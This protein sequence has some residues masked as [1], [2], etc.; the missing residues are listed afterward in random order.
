MKKALIWIMLFFYL[1]L[2][3]GCGLLVVAGAGAA[4]GYVLRDKGYEVKS[5]VEKTDEEKK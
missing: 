1:M 2:T 5:P 4:G 3:S